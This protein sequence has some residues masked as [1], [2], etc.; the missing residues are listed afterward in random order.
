VIV[1]R[2]Q[3]KT[4]PALALAVFSCAVTSQARA[5]TRT[6]WAQAVTVGDAVRSL[7][8]RMACGL[9]WCEAAKARYAFPEW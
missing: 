6:V 9:D 8:G 1:E 4:R 2:P 7:V 3:K 5:M